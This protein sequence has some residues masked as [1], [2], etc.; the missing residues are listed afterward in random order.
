MEAS[1][2]KE[3]DSLGIFDSAK[4]AAEANV[5]KEALERIEA[6]IAKVPKQE[7]GQPA[8]ADGEDEEQ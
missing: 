7:E 2:M 1:L 8:K 4:Q 3:A 6:E 5:Y